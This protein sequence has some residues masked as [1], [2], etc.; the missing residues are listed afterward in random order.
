MKTD[1][2]DVQFPIWLVGDSPPKN[3]QDKLEYPLDPRHPIRHNI[4]TP[5]L[6]VIQDRV[7]RRAGSRVDTSSIYIRN[8]VSDRSR[9][10]AGND[11]DWSPSTTSEVEAFAGL[12]SRWHPAVVLCFGAFAFEFARRA[13]SELPQRAWN[14]WRTIS[15][16][17]EFRERMRRFD[18]PGTNVIPL[19]HRSIS[20]GKFL[21][22][23]RYF[24]DRVGANYFEYVGMCIADRLLRFQD[25]LPIWV[26]PGSNALNAA[27]T[28]DL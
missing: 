15:L 23:H 16:G 4:W 25:A 19:L 20:G 17:A 13:S 11:A 27:D 8:A 7:F 26:R 5:V 24:C 3:W 28:A 6:E 10:P 1:N 9:K 2:G 14:Y 22:S 18:I 21:E 12:V